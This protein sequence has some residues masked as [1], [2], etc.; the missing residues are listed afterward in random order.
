LSTKEIKEKSGD[1]YNIL[2]IVIIR[3]HGPAMN[4]TVASK[5]RRDGVVGVGRFFGIALS[6]VSH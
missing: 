2:T 5:R 4:V 1:Y 6:C 3:P